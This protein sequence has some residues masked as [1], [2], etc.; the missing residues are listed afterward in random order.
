MALYGRH[1]SLKLADNPSDPAW[2]WFILNGPHGERFQWKRYGELSRDIETLEKF[3]DERS[4]DD[5]EF[6]NK[7]RDISLSSLSKDNDILIRTAIQVLTIVGDEDD[8]QIVGNFVNDEN[9]DIKND[10]KCALFERGLKIKKR[11]QE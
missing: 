10:A 2:R 6:K 9:T 3:I 4:T 11:I 1:E 5:V 8:M 7:I